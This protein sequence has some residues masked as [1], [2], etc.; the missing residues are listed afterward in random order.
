MAL[1]PHPLYCWN[2][3]RSFKKT[4]YFRQT[5]IP[6]NVWIFVILLPFS[7]KTSKAIEKRSSKCLEFGHPPPPQWAMIPKLR[8][9]LPF[10]ISQ[11]K[12]RQKRK[13]TSFCTSKICLVFADGL[14]MKFY[15]ILVSQSFRLAH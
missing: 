10:F 7:W 9:F 4:P 3:L 12:M 5:K 2:P 11:M 13:K 8:I 6:Q 14:E 15:L 1:T